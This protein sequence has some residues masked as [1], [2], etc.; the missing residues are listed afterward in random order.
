MTQGGLDRYE[1]LRQLGRSPGSLPC[2]T[3]LARDRADGGEV[4]VKLLHLDRMTGWKRLEL[5]E[6][7]AGALKAMRHER[8]PAFR[9]AFR[10]P[11]DAA[12]VFVLVRAYVPGASLREKVDSG[13]RF[14]EADVMRIGA[15]LLEIVGYIHGLRPPF[16]HRDI[17]PD[18]VILGEGDRVFLVDFGGVQ[19]LR[20]GP[21]GG[22][23]V[24]TPGYAA[25]EQFVGR[26]TPRS[27]LY[28][29][30]ATLVFLLT[31]RNPADLPARAMK[32]DYR[33]AT[34]VSAPLARVLDSWL[35]P[36][37]ERRLLSETDA[38]ALLAGGPAGV[39]E[40]AAP[41]TPPYGEP[42]LFSAAK[43][44]WGSR[45]SVRRGPDFTRFHVPERGRARG[46]A[47]LGGFSLFWLAFVG[48]WTYASISLRAPVFFPLFS[49]PFWCAGLFMAARV[50]RGLFGTV[51]LSLGPETLVF[52]RSF[53]RTITVP[54]SQVGRI[55]LEEGSDRTARGVLCV[56]AGARVL[57][58]GEQL[59][60]PE[61]EWL[62]SALQ[63]C[64]RRMRGEP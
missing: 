52:T 54:L 36:D 29:L 50:F 47:A 57:R 5:F 35:E 19:D 39:T 41:E 25:F 37:A 15:E 61:R 51:T 27:D 38:L 42:P 64:Q 62:C 1:R 45:M 11:G 12:P 49:I 8:I 14:T 24:G 53:S 23:V 55:T 2:E 10:L 6:R 9:E 46:L 33:A 21:D 56:E 60:S 32:V 28:A 44:P 59:S 48:F 58:F 17:N 63:D 22:T 4:V 3:F 13:W 34:S 16:I 40:S 18:N 20:E 43:P 26:A 7:E 31:H 30:A